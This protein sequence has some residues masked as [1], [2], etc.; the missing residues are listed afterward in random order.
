[1][2]H[3]NFRSLLKFPSRIAA[4]LTG[5]GIAGGIFSFGHTE[6]AFREAPEYYQDVDVQVVQSGP[7]L[8]FSD[9]PE[10][11]YEN[12][13]LYKD[14]V[15]GEGRVFFHHVNGMKENRKLSVL[16]RPV[17]R[18]A[19][20]TWGCRG[21][22]DPDKSYY[23]SALKGQKRYFSEYKFYWKKARKNSLKD[24]RKV[25]RKKLAAGSGRPDY[26][27]YKT[28]SD[29][30][31]TML[32]QG[33]YLEMLTKERNTANAGIRLKPEQLLTG[34]FDFHAD[35]P[36]EVVVMITHPQQDINRFSRDGK[37]LPM[38]EHPLRGTYENADLT[39]VVKNP[40]Q[41]KWYQAKALCMGSSDDRLFLQ[42]FDRLTGAKTR[43]H[44]NYGVVY[45]IKYSVDGEHSVQLGVNPWGGD[46]YGAG[47]H[48]IREQATVSSIPHEDKYFGT[49]YE[50]DT[51][52]D[53]SVHM[54]KKIG[55]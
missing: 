36:M 53:V 28:V 45:H 27:F 51:V 30:P 9:S 48:I 11:V 4:I 42:G 35:H 44:G 39:Y 38:D 8:L 41:L 13:I 52:I 3:M 1:M 16:I 25:G 6:A 23:I 12:G 5:F 20:I 50:L 31:A 37:V 2:I 55:S 19:T 26:S 43:N 24:S 15:E 32:M 14:I 17:N 54:S 22:G 21:V 18:I 40:L 33:E 29:L 47:L 34:M 10:I 7:T 49:G 46:F